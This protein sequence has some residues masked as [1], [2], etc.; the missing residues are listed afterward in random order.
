[1]SDTVLFVD[2]EENILSSI[3]RLFMDE[4]FEVLTASS[5][6]E[7]LKVLGTRNDV[8]LI[9]S[10]QRMPG[11][12]GAEF[13]AKAREIVPD[14]LRMVLTGY[15]D[16]NAAVS[17]INEGGACRYMSKPWNDNEFIQAVKDALQRQRLLEENRQLNAIVQQ[18]NE[19]LKEWNTRL[20]ERVLEQTAQV[21]KRN[22]ELR[23]ISGKLKENYKNSVSALAW[24]ME[25]RAGDS[26]NHGR[27]VSQIAG[28]AATLLKL[29]ADEV[30]T[31]R[32]AALLHDLGKIVTPDE[33]LKQA[34]ETLIGKELEEYKMHAVRG[35]TAVDSIESLRAAGLLIRHHHERFDGKGF[36]DKLKGKDIPTGAMII[37]IADSVDRR[38]GEGWTEQDLERL[39]EDLKIGIGN[40]FDPE[41]FPVVEKA[42]RAELVPLA[43]KPG[44]TEE[45]MEA[46]LLQ[47][48]M[49]LSRDVTSGS[50]LLLLNKG[51]VLDHVMIASIRRYYVMDPPAG[52]VWIHVHGKNA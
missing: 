29:P 35:Q 22:D 30:E 10:D 11:M 38:L 33:V 47:T 8:A 5:G 42:I 7:G 2:D 15:A 26:S 19:E 41:L 23:Q 51:V 17:A 27:H 49:V 6:E 34:P 16:I 21:V 13:L 45:E 14:A 40:A 32:T 24:L 39:V 4:D 25:L 44:Q 52:G 9:V 37:A 46:I 50:G 3:R 12:S 48:G 20:K 31:I 28:R 36:P 43:N 18:Q 1:M